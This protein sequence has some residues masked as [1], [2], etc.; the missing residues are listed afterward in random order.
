MLDNEKIMNVA[1]NEAKKSLK[2]KD[3]PVGAVI[4]YKNRIISKAHNNKNIKKC[5]I[6]HAEINTIII[7]NKKL[8]NERLDN[9]VLYVTMEHSQMCKKIIIK[10]KIKKIVYGI[11]NKNNIHN[12]LLTNCEKVEMQ[13]NVLKND[14]E[15]MMKDFFEEIRNK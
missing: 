10:K 4:V 12:L 14:I 1:L 11:K 7:T 6:N 5:C 2:T 9:C 3:V 13:N 8:K 15:K